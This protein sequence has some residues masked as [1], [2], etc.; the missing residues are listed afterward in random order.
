[1]ARLCMYTVT[2]T[3]ISEGHVVSICNVVEEFVD[4]Q[5]LTLY[6]EMSI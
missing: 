3:D 6:I 5:N 2:G 4:S 1:M